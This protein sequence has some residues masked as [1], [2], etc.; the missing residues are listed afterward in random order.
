[1]ALILNDISEINSNAN[2]INSEN[3]LLRIDE[4][5]VKIINCSICGTF[6][7]DLMIEEE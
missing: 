1:V 6:R 2:L 4:M 3:V 7:E 5:L